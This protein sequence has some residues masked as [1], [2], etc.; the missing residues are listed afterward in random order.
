VF[1][2]GPITV[3]GPVASGCCGSGFLCKILN[4][5]LA[6]IKGPDWSVFTGAGCDAT[7]PSPNILGPPLSDVNPLAAASSSFL[8]I[9]LVSPTRVSSSLS[10]PEVT[11]T[12][13]EVV[14]VRPKACGLTLLFPPSLAFSP[15][16][17]LCP[18]PSL[19]FPP[20]L[21]LPFPLPVPAA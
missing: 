15:P 16:S 9:E 2:L 19:L 5:L 17:R 3:V 14:G 4:L 6:D 10:T 18:P 13:I 1:S 8:M 21:L 11:V 12:C 20:P 7:I